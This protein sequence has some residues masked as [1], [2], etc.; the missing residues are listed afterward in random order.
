MLQGSQLTHHGLLPVSRC[1]VRIGTQ[2]S[3]S[4]A[5]AR[6]CLTMARMPVCRTEAQAIARQR[7]CCVTSHRR[8]AGALQI[9]LRIALPHSAPGG[10]NRGPASACEHPELEN[11]SMS[12]CTAGLYFKAQSAGRRAP[13]CGAQ[14]GKLY[15][16]HMLAALPYHVVEPV[17]GTAQPASAG[18]P[19]AC[20]RLAAICLACGGI[21][22]CLQVKST[23]SRITPP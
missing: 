6:N 12:C 18:V 15:M 13:L 14:G 23:V 20:D 19:K 3:A 4:H 22:L 11:H 16:H 10:G 2:T 17:P 7:T 8:L 5:H 21:Q 1:S 9:D